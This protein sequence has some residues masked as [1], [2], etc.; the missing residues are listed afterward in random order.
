M[1]MAETLRQDHA[2][3]RRKLA[4]LASVLQ[5]GPEARFVLREMCFS[6]QRLLQEHIEREQQLMAAA[7]R[8]HANEHTQTLLRLRGVNELLLGGV[9]ASVPRVIVRLSHLID[10]LEP[11]MAAQEHAL[12]DLGAP[13]PAG[14]RVDVPISGAM[15]VN[16]ILCRY[17]HAQP[18]F[19]QFHINRLQEG[20]E[21]VDE[22][23]WRHGLDASQL[24][25]RLRQAVTAPIN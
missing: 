4:L 11:Q 15:S 2:S 14:S 17:P 5:M 21:S 9:R 19:E 3:L 22:L 1:D 16:E 7:G 25:E 20:Y 23:A 13:W 10:D 12:A 18:L 8:I 24:L 6:L